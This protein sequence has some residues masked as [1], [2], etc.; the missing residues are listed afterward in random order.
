MGDE[1]RISVE[2]EEETPDIF[3]VT[4]GNGMGAWCN[5]TV[6]QY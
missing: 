1:A 4:A 3:L 6:F 2:F 5:P